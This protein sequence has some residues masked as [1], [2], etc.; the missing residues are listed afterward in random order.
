MGRARARNGGEVQ[1]DVSR[2][3]PGGGGLPARRRAGGSAAEVQVRAGADH[4]R[5]VADDVAVRVVQAAPATA[6][7]L[8]HRDLAE[9]VALLYQVAAAGGALGAG[10]AVPAG[11]GLLGLRARVG[12]E[13]DDAPG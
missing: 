7:V 4:V 5:V 11:V 2:R 6:H 3:P 13:R 1:P 12:G 10:A 9:R 8:L